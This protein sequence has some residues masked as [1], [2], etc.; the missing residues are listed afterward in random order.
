[1]VLKEEE[2]FAFSGKQ[3]DSAPAVSCTTVMNVQKKNQHQKTSPP[4]EP[5]T[6]SGRR[7]SRKRDFQRQESVEV[8]STAV[9]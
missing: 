9:Q 8:Q 5:P 6:P 7:A 1:M 4:S 2:E 3:K